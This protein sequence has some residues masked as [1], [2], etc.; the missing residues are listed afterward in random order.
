MPHSSSPA[1]RARAAARLG[2]RRGHLAQ[3]RAERP[4]QL[5][6][7]ARRVALP[8][9][10]LPRL[11]RG[12]GDQHPVVGDVLDPPG[13]RAEQEHVA[14]ARLVDHLLVQLA[15]PAAGL[16]RAG[17]QEDA[18]QAAV[19]DRAAAGHR[20]PLRARPAGQRAGD[21]VP[22]Q[23]RPQLGELVGRVAPGQHVQHRLQRRGRQRRER[24]GAG[25]P[26]RPA[27]PR[28]RRPARPSRRSA[29]PAR[30]AGCA[31]SASP[32]SARPASARRRRSTRPGRRGTSGTSRR[33]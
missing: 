2:G 13:R 5:H 19:G 32:R 21:P 6:R 17:G 29:G 16:A 8:E 23:P 24:R 15:D 20:Q 11:S 9:R 22:D 3:E 1:A 28:S 33:G 12:R 7:P 31:G 14:D 18:E 4:A 26:A 10:H 27:R 25:G 30:R